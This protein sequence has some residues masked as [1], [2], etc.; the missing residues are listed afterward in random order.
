MTNRQDGPIPNVL[1]KLIQSQS[2][3]LYEY[4]Q[5]FWDPNLW[6]QFYRE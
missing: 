5:V 2:A 1:G 3:Y 6:F 4:L